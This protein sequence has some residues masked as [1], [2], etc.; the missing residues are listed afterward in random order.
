MVTR[1]ENERVE[2][3]VIASNPVGIH[4]SVFSF[5]RFHLPIVSGILIHRVITELS[6]E[7]QTN[8]YI[9]KR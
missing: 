3:L 8:D 2:R 5:S 7:M 9:L 4:F 1:L 6:F